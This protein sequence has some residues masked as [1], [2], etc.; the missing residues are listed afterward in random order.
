MG[1]PKDFPTKHEALPEAEFGKIL[2][3]ASEGKPESVRQLHALH[4]T[5][6]PDWAKGG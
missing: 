4:D 2:K 3:E 5:K 1:W 6:T